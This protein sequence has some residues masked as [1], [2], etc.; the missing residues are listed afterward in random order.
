L[1]RSIERGDGAGVITSEMEGNAEIAPGP[2]IR[3]RGGDNTPPGFRLCPI[4]DAGL[5]GRQRGQE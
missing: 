5:L 4:I 2:G 3:G 1:E